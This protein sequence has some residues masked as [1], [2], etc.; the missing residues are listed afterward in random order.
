M[1]IAVF[2]D[3]YLEVAGGIP[4]S[5]RA[6]KE[7]LEKLGH[8]VVVFCPG[9]SCNEKNVVIVPTMKHLKINGAPMA[10]GPRKVV[11][12]VKNQYPVFSQFDIVHVHYEASCSI[13]GVLLAREFKVPLVQTMHGRED[14]AIAV[15][16]P[17]PF[18]TIVAS[19]LNLLHSN[20]LPNKRIVLRD[21]QL[22]N[23]TA[24]AMM[25]TLMVNQ[26]NAADR[27]ITPSRQ[28]AEKLEKYGV[29]R[30]ISVVSNGVA[31]ELAKGKWPVRKRTEDEPLKMIWNSRVSRE[32]RIMPFLKAL[33]KIANLPFSL[34]VYGDGNEL[35]R[36]RR[37]AERHELSKKVEFH[38]AV[39]HDLLLD[40]MRKMHLSVTVSYGFDTQGLTLL[41]ATATGLP[42]FYCDPDLAESV[43]KGAGICT[44]NPEAVEM[45]KMLR[46]IIETP[47]CIAEMSQ[48]AL[49]ARKQ[50]LQSTQIK[51]LLEV[52][53][54][55]RSNGLQQ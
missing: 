4:S 2:T 19:A 45:A 28:F 10:K 36:A 37:Y 30:P 44:K 55:V 41:E 8:E 9:F 24:K 21:D 31:D 49:V 5:I 35:N 18:K 6:Q 14:M 15:N 17:H 25:W 32:K 42:V 38:G 26:A 46:D 16:V 22:A 48:A 27:V 7:A 39:A 34:D 52:Y 3:L 43:P 33:V 54:S 29:E 12:F 11:G 1:K 40:K 47:E 50:A 23:T 51:K 13:A 53:A 20:Y